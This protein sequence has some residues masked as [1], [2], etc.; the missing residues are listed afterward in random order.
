MVYIEKIKGKM[1]TD[2]TTSSYRKNVEVQN[3]T[4]PA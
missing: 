3:Q 2:T 1:E 4:W